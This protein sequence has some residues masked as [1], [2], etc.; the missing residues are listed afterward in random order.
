MPPV[1]WVREPFLGI[2]WPGRE[3][4]RLPPSCIEVKNEWS[5]ACTL[6]MYLHGVHR[7]KNLYIAKFRNER[8]GN[9]AWYVVGQ[10][11]TY[12]AFGPQRP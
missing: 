4:D 5:F 3:V 7:K 6:P 11:V 1:Q 2:K 9:I 12:F 8:L 10:V